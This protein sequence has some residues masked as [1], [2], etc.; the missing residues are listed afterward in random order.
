MRVLATSESVDRKNKLRFGSRFEY[1]R[2]GK[3]GTDPAAGPPI[4]PRSVPIYI[5]GQYAGEQVRVAF[6]NVGQGPSQSKAESR[7]SAT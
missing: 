4:V 5:V 3:P 2:Y 7:N 6:G 1:G